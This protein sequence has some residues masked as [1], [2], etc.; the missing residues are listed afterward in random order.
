MLER[1]SRGK[2]FRAPGAKEQG[3]PVADKRT[4][5]P[6]V[7][8]AEDKISQLWLDFVGSDRSDE[9][10]RDRLIIHYIPL[11]NYVASKKQV[12]L[13]AHVDLDDLRSDGLVGLIHAID[14]YDPSKGLKFSTYAIPR[15][16]GEMVDR[17]RDLDIVPRSVRQL[18]RKINTEVARVTAA[19]ETVDWKQVASNL[20]LSDAELDKALADI[21]RS[22]I[23]TLDGLLLG[24]DE[25]AAALYDKLP[26][27]NAPDPHREAEKE[28][29]YQA[30]ARAVDLLPERER[31]VI[32]NF[33]YEERPLKEIAAHLGVTESR[34]SQLQAQAT[35]RLRQRLLAYQFVA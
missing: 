27:T 29:R 12:Q 26:D 22:P 20:D 33:F 14:R 8:S 19:G 2:N 4:V 21:A 7:S 5:A 28:E 1:W 16:R 11:V 15:I 24:E 17:M 25:E 18:E 9:L 6:A 10:L 13:P 32:I 35:Q 3:W 34:V 31:M 23:H 30:L